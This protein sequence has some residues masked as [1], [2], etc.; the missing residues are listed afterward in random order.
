LSPTKLSGI[1]LP[2]CITAHIPTFFFT[3]R[4][5]RSP[6]GHRESPKVERSARFGCSLQF[7]RIASS[8]CVLTI[9]PYES[10]RWICDGNVVANSQVGNIQCCS[11]EE[12]V[13]A[14]EKSGDGGIPT[15]AEVQWTT[16]R[17]SVLLIDHSTFPL[18]G[19]IRV[20]RNDQTNQ[21]NCLYH[22]GRSPACASCALILRRHS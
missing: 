15:G 11:T 1:E 5:Q 8:M 16:G 22:I 6:D 21:Y 14:N 10:M 2:F 18:P 19:K 12:I 17:A 4:S 7:N 13:T 20:N 3:Q 9:V